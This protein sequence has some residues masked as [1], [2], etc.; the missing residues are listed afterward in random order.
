[1]CFIYLLHVP[2]LQLLPILFISS[3]GF[4]LLSSALLF[5]PEELPSEFLIRPIFSPHSPDPTGGQVLVNHPTQLCSGLE[6]TDILAVLNLLIG[7]WELFVY[8]I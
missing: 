3:C 8:F 6:R 1:M 5:Q 2:V 7:E 4:Q